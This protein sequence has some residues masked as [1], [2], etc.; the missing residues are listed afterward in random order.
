MNK[1]CHVLVF[2]WWWKTLQIL[3]SKILAQPLKISVLCCD[4]VLTECGVCD[5]MCS[6]KAG[7]YFI[8]LEGPARLTCSQVSVD[9]KWQYSSPS[10]IS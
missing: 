7:L 3:V 4:Q 9:G 5:E 1:N 10:L 8:M 6:N 2:C